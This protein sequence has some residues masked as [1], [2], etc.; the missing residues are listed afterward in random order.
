VGHGIP[1]PYDLTRGDLLS[2]DVG[3]TLDGWVADAA[4]TLAVGPASEP[5]PHLA[6]LGGA[7]ESALT[8]I[9]TGAMPSEHGVVG[10]RMIAGELPFRANSSASILSW[11]SQKISASTLKRSPTIVFAA[12][13]PPSIAGSTASI[14]MRLAASF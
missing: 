9:T 10:Y 4:C 12:K 1:G 11:P 8:S 7:G 13:R 6:P 5:A 2:L 3:G 14:A